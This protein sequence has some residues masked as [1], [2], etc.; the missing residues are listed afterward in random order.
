MKTRPALPAM[1]GRQTS[2]PASRARRVALALLGAA[3]ATPA[4]A[5]SYTYTTLDAP[6]S[7]FTSPT[8]IN[9]RGEVVGWFR[10]AAGAASAN[11]GFAWRGGTF[12]VVAVPSPSPSAGSFL[13]DVDDAG[14]AVG[15]YGDVLGGDRPLIFRTSDGSLRLPNSIS[16]PAT[17]TELRSINR[18]KVAVGAVS[19]N[20]GQSAYGLILAGNVATPVTVPGASVVLLERIND[21]G[22]VLGTYLTQ[23]Y[24][25]FVLASGQVTDIGAPPGSSYSVATSL[26]EDGKVIGWAQFATRVSGFVYDGQAFTVFSYPG[27]AL[28]TPVARNA[29]GIFGTSLAPNSTSYQ[30]FVKN[31][32]GYHAISVPGSTSTAIAAANRRGDFAGSYQDSAGA[33][34]GFTATCAPDQAPCTQ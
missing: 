22:T 24:H 13:W 20:M 32:G 4:W 14:I 5:G 30:G 17:V 16:P 18:H 33:T 8:A 34:H 11:A 10:P 12:S 9:D 29:A 15:Q 31:A 19:S 23:G 6:G 25:D 21:A 1:P 28:T 7:Q 3:S 26:G 2:G 27:A